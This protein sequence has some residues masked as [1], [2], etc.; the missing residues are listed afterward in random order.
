MPGYQNQGYTSGYQGQEYG[1]NYGQVYNSGYQGQTYGS[2][3]YGTGYQ[4]QS[5][6][7]DYLSYMAMFGNMEQVQG[8]LGEGMAEVFSQERLEAIQ[9]ARERAAR[10][11]AELAAERQQATRNAEGAQ[12]APNAEAAQSAPNA[13]G[14]QATSEVSQAE[15]GSNPPTSEIVETNPASQ[16]GQSASQSGEPIVGEQPGPET[17]A[18]QQQGGA[19]GG[20]ANQASGEASNV[21]MQSKQEALPPSH[22]TEQSQIPRKRPNIVFLVYRN[23]LQQK[24]NP[25]AQGQQIQTIKVQSI[26]SNINNTPQTS[27]VAKKRKTITK[28]K[29][30]L[31]KK[32]ALSGSQAGQVLEKAAT[33]KVNQEFNTKSSMAMTESGIPYIQKDALSTNLVVPKANPG[34]PYSVSG[35]TKTDP[36]APNADPGAPNEPWEQTYLVES[37][38]LPLFKQLPKRVVESVYQQSVP[39]PD[40][41]RSYS[42]QPSNP[43]YQPTGQN[44]PKFYRGEYR[45]LLFFL[46]NW[47]QE[48][49]STH[50]LATNKSN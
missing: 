41:S 18:S 15:V 50:K 10:E 2:Q 40:T 13:E 26:R 27:N 28:V 9:S 4:S 43:S 47:F 31:L 8:M 30:Q 7:T 44:Q 24:S 35:V 38:R 21:N 32:K 20:E 1:S 3:R 11:R 22:M 25:G 16:S 19:I 12:A 42:S 6:P 23:G 45:K 36:G 29:K 34:E 5:S 39:A 33:K 17:G 46:L 37:N 14:Q 49:G 48:T